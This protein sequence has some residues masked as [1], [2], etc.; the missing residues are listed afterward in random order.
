MDR[1]AKL[2]AARNKLAKFQKAK[3]ST[4]PAQR[5]ESEAISRGVEPVSENGH[6][7]SNGEASAPIPFSMNNFSGQKPSNGQN[8][9]ALEQVELHATREQLQEQHSRITELEV[10]LKKAEEQKESNA[11]NAVQSIQQLQ[12][13]L[14][15][16]KSQNEVLQKTLT[17]E[18]SKLNQ[19][20]F[21]KDSEI[22]SLKSGKLQAEQ[23]SQQL[24]DQLNQLQHQVEIYQGQVSQ[25]N[26]QN[27]ANQHQLSGKL[28]E[29][30]MTIEIL[31]EEKA[32]LN[33]RVRQLEELEISLRA[34]LESSLS[35]DKNNSENLQ[36]LRQENKRLN[37][38]NQQL[39]NQID[40]KDS[41]IK[42]FQ[43]TSSRL[44]SEIDIIMLKDEDNKLMIEQLEAQIKKFQQINASL[45]EEKNMAEASLM[46]M[47]S[48]SD[49]VLL[50]RNR[51]MDIVNELKARVQQQQY[52][53]EEI[54]SE[55]DQ[56]RVQQ[57]ATTEKSQAAINGLAEK[58]ETS[59]MEKEMLQEEVSVLREQCLVRIYLDHIFG[60]MMLR[61]KKNGA[62]DKWRPLLLESSL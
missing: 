49:A 32:E 23:L 6:Q 1:N 25:N 45:T 29:Q 11:T 41:K 62:P 26:S 13:V 5:P 28:L 35:S 33:T 61:R 55:R 15:D 34:N 43:Q 12:K 44:K 30:Q 60:L 24:N 22:S 54:S 53:L 21:V 14:E 7:N 19:L 39:S 58:L 17:D 51:L 46:Q 27:V 40:E 4:T 2:A 57:H 59:L 48:G 42:K 56:Y 3:Q 37:E 47:S 9:S 8:L 20:S 31:V 18:Q 36:N 16:T 10:L 50:E 38:S 52:Q